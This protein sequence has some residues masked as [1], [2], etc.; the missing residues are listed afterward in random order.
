MRSRRSATLATALVFAALPL[1]ASATMA[2]P[3]AGR[4]DAAR[5]QHEAILAYWTPQRM[6][7]AVP[8]DF[9]LDPGRGF[10]PAAQPPGTP[11]G[12]GG[13]GG[14][15]VLTTTSGASWPNNLGEIYSAEG[16]VFFTMS[17]VNYVCSGT[18]VEDGVAD[19]SIVLTAGHC[20]YDETVNNSDNGFASNWMFV[21]RYDATPTVN[22][23]SNATTCWTA[24]ELVVHLGWAT[25]G[26]FNS[27]AIRYDWAF[28]VVAP[29]GSTQ[30]DTTFGAFPIAASTSYGSG[31]QTFAF[32]YPAAQKYKG[33]DLTY[34]AGP[35][36]FDP[37]QADATYRLTCNMTG[38]S[39]GGGWLI[40]FTTD[41]NGG[42]LGSVNSYGYADVKAM[43]GPKFN[44]DT[45]DTWSAAQT[46]TFDT[47]KRGVIVP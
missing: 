47:S 25:S 13:G 32:G 42:T 28:A 35:L 26:G 17:G 7:A 24:Q 2:A 21:P 10:Q 12:G 30:L 22:C 39:S 5:S 15:G 46:A 40:D 3:G 33:Y 36:G 18:V 11:G 19:R 8:R 45:A 6:A 9:V 38:G 43:H 31:E 14:G 27:T 23:F 44:G 41:G 4:A 1:F 34:C 20:A 29:N 37:R 16:K